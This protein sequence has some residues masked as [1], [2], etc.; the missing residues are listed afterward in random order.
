MSTTDTPTPAPDDFPPLTYD[1]AVMFFADWLDG[2]HHIP[3]DV[4]PFGRGWAIT[5]AGPLS[6]FDT[7]HLTKLVFLAHDRC[8]RVEIQPAHRAI[9]IA[10][11]QRAKRNG[12]LDDRHP[13][14]DQALACHRQMFSAQTVR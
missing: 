13:T 1:D 7:R 14:I 3:G 2:K 10:I 5:Y 4:R 9:T 11:W 12:V 6:T 8:V